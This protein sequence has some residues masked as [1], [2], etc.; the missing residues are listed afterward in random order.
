MQ[1]QTN[2]WFNV[3]KKS[4]QT[5]FGWWARMLAV[6]LFCMDFGPLAAGEV[7]L[8]L[9]D[10]ATL[11]FTVD[12][13]TWLS[14]D[15]APDGQQMVIE[16]LGDLYTLPID[17]GKATPLQRGM[18]F[19]SQPR[20]SPDGKHLVYISDRSGSDNVWLM[21]LET[22][23]T[24][25]LSKAQPRDELASPTFSP[26]GKHVVVSRGGWS[27]RTHELWAYPVEGGKGVRL[28]KGKY[29][30][31]LPYGQWHNALGAA[32]EPAG[33]Y[34]YYAYKTGG[35]GYD[36]SF[37][38]WQVVRRDMLHG[39][40]DLITRAPGSAV[41]PMVSRDGQWLVYGTR[42][43]QQTGLRLRRLASG[44]EDWL[45]YPV[46]RDTQE[47]R[48]TRDLLPGYAFTPDSR[49]LITSRDGGL[50]KVDLA[51]RE[52]TSIPF[53]V[54]VELPVAERL[55]FPRRIGLGPVKARLLADPQLS[56]D[57]GRL[58][59][60]AFAQIWVYDLQ[61]GKASAITPPDINGGMPSWSP[62]GK[63]VVYAS[64][65]DG[66]GALYKQRPNARA[67]PQRLTTANGYFTYPVWSP[68]GQQI[69]AL[70][71]SA[72]EHRQRLSGFAQVVGADLVWLPAAGGPATTIIPARGFGR[73]HFGPEAGRVYLSLAVGPF[74]SGHSDGL[75]SVRMDGTDRRQHLSVQGPGHY[76]FEDTANPEA[77][78]RSPDG[79]FVAF[80]HAHQLY[81]T[82]PL[83]WV[84]KQQLKLANPDLPLLK[85]TDVGAD[86]FAWST[87][88]E[89]L[90]WSSGDAVY[91]RGVDSFV[92]TA[93]EQPADLL[94]SLAQRW[95][96]DI[97][98]PRHE[99]SAS[100]ALTGATA[101]TMDPDRGGSVGLL[102]DAVVL[103]EGD[104]IA[105]VGHRDAVA[106]PAG[107]QTFDLS[108]KYLLPGFV[109]THAHV[110]IRRELFDSREWSLLANLA[111]GVTTLM[112]VQPSSVDILDV[113][114]RV[115]AGRL[116]GPRTYSTGPGLFANADLKSYEQAL[117]VL[118][119]YKERY[120]V[121]NIKAYISGSREQRQWI[122]QAAREVQIMPTTEGAL[123]LL[124]D[125]TFAID[126]FSGLE[127]NFPLPHV[128]DDVVQLAARTRL[129]YTPTILVN[130][131]G[132]RAEHVFY[133]EED[134]YN[135]PKV[136]RFI[137]YENLAARSLRRR[138]FH[139]QEYVYKEVAASAR[140]IL[141]AGGQVGVGSH[142]QL[143]GLAFHWE[144]RALASGG[145]TP[146][147][148]LRSAT[149]MGAEMLGIGQDVGSIETGKLADLLVLDKN[150]LDDLSHTE[151]LHW[152][153]RGGE[154][155]RAATLDQVWP[156]QQALAPQWWQ[157]HKL[158]GVVEGD[159]QP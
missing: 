44:E 101:L 126:G 116:L 99:P 85:M 23:K 27:R 138:W 111:Y 83:P 18:A 35:F 69:V 9:Q 57:G 130:F 2:R 155:Y 12:E 121:H 34:L 41:R 62:D 125:I 45:I 107:V 61:T 118:R 124:M 43:K 38:S 16:V 77:L 17:G 94:E 36:I 87:D 81:V 79:Q 109:D 105:A 59:F 14:V 113:E 47:A 49:F 24:R 4:R 54:D 51:T 29:R 82:R 128:Y 25:Q 52:V 89:A 53:S 80:K 134:P 66:Q 48:F 102:E 141:E 132:P 157:N 5:Q 6:T 153:M 70:R 123:D 40:E 88:G 11:A 95:P 7:A 90:L 135:D 156:E 104:R 117:A 122:A 86:Y 103:I 145:M 68:D 32:Y 136:Q 10:D 19:D 140:R 108:G 149:L 71:G 100:V 13:V 120:G 28:S 72:A 144:M 147:Q 8:P 159:T 21:N 20:F 58:V 148:V 150:P 133:I 30:A 67:K 63:Y 22:G 110:P 55:E 1:R 131:G 31:N 119:R 50:V 26:D 127:H 39:I 158:P 112:D 37:P 143:Q 97:Y 74:P 93:D 33:R 64:W 98:L 42:H 76:R 114:A 78:L 73:P 154:I 15:V 3:A 137:P 91:S 129:A 56:P 46:E 84:Q 65:Q 106:L 146:A 142:G 75:I 60:A 139:P 92:F 115:K 151:A 152:V 96:I